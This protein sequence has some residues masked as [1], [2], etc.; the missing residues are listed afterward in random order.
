MR[1]LCNGAVQT[2]VT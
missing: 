2:R 1:D